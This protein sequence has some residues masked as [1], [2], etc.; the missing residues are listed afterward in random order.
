MIHVI[1]RFELILSPTNLADKLW[2]VIV[3]E[4]NIRKYQIMSEETDIEEFVWIEFQLF[5]L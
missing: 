4:S 5:R 2:D 1:L 3:T